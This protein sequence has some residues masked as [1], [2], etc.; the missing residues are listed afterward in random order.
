M[1]TVTEER[2]SSLEDSV[3]GE[4]TLIRERLNCF[5]QVLDNS[6]EMSEGGSEQ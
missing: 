5:Q 4:D 2:E 3:S 6:M 1:R